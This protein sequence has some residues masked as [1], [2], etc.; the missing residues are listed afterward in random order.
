M[1]QSRFLSIV[2]RHEEMLNDIREME[3]S[4][5]QLLKDATLSR[6]KFFSNKSKSDATKNK[7]SSEN[8]VSFLQ[9]SQ[10]RI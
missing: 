6:K 10:K 2:R 8:I 5:S 4:V 1:A 7:I 3:K 9:D